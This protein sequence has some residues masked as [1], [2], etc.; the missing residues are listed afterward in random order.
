MNDTKKHTFSDTPRHRL[1]SFACIQ[2]IF[3]LSSWKLSL[4]LSDTHSKKLHFRND[5]ST[6]LFIRK[7]ESLT[8]KGRER[9]VCCDQIT[10][11]RCVCVCV[12][13]YIVHSRTWESLS[14]I[15]FGSLISWEREKKKWLP[16]PPLITLL[17]RKSKTKKNN[18]IE[19]RVQLN[20]LET[21]IYSRKSR[22]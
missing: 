20:E 11:K 14:F 4:Q 17:R 1:Q 2:L 13:C 15:T 21:H 22:G 8:S 19:L 5:S 9:R 18:W 7:P 3:F 16:S 10:R 6:I 12:V